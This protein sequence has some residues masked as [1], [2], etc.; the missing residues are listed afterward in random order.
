MSAVNNKLLIFFLLHINIEK[1]KKITKPSILEMPVIL[2]FVCNRFL[3]SA[4]VAEL[5]YK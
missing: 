4:I 1:I 5:K 3:P 2:G